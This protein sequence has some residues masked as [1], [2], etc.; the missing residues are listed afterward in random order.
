[1]LAVDVA[2]KLTANSFPDQTTATWAGPGIFFFSCTYLW[3]DYSTRDQKLM[4]FP[5]DLQKLDLDVLLQELVK[6][7]KQGLP[8]QDAGFSHD[9]EKLVHTFVTSRLEN[10]ISLLSRRPWSSFRS[11]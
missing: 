1:M 10:C 7:F 11:L 6:V 9:A 2:H 8:R 4:Y 3:Q 5:R